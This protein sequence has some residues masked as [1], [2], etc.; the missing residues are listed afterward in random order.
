MSKYLKARMLM[1]TSLAASALV[2]CNQSMAGTSEALSACK[3]K[4]KEDPRLGS[5]EFVY[6]RMDDMKVKGRYTD[7]TLDVNTRDADGEKAAWQ[8]ECRARGSGKV[9][10]LELSPLNDDT[11]LASK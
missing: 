10:S 9:V 2:L 6:A 8:A 3:S 4:I 5:E 11:A 1:R 7:F